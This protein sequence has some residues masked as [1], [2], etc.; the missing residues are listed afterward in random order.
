MAGPAFSSSGRKCFTRWDHHDGA[1]QGQ[2]VSRGFTKKVHEPPAS[3]L[4]PAAP[5]TEQQFMS[6][7]QGSLHVHLLDALVDAG[8]LEWNQ[9]GYYRLHPVIAAYARAFFAK[10]D[11]QERL[12]G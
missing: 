2:E 3:A 5:F 6:L 10:N 4:T 8:L 1:A 11:E 9:H 12:A 7:H